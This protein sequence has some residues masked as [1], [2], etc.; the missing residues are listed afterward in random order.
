ML[1]MISF[2]GRV[3]DELSLSPT[4]GTLQ[5]P[6]CQTKSSGHLSTR[7][8]HSIVFCLCLLVLIVGWLRFMSDEENWWEG[9]KKTGKRTKT[10]RRTHVALFHSVC[11]VP[12]SEFINSW[13]RWHYFALEQNHMNCHYSSLFRWGYSVGSVDSP[14]KTTVMNWKFA[15]CCETNRFVMA[16]RYRISAKLWAYGRRCVV[17]FRKELSG[18]KWSNVRQRTLVR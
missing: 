11:I 15:N 13:L 1:A 18:E 14:P 4:L 17:S 3:P 5:S 9:K 8:T 6:R 10:H 2:H 7:F 16:F 12:G